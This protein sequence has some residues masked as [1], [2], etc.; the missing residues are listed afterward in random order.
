MPIKDALAR[1]WVA[2]SLQSGHSNAT[3][4]PQC[5]GNEMYFADGTHH[6]LRVS[7]GPI[8]RF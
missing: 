4:H 3:V 1:D 5:V 7:F 8:L 6:N 2:L